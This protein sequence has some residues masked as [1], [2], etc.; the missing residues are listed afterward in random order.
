[1]GT[2]RRAA[3]EPDGTDPVVGWGSGDL[4]SSVQNVNRTQVSLINSL[5]FMSL[6]HYVDNIQ[7][8]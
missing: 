6:Q 2:I 7:E 3:A 1:M 8:S 4:I 5:K